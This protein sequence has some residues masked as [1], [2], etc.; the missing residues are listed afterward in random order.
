M[1]T[2]TSIVLTNERNLDITE[3]DDIT[4]AMFQ[5]YCAAKV[6]TRE[7]EYK[8][9]YLIRQGGKIGKQA[10]NEMVLRNMRLVIS[11]AKKYQGR[12]LSLVDLV[13]EGAIGLLKAVRKFDLGRGCRFSTMATWWIRQTIT[14]A[15]DDKCNTIRLPVHVRAKLRTI[16]KNWY[17]YAQDTGDYPNLTITGEAIGISESN[18]EATL[19]TMKMRPISLN[20]TINDSGDL[21]G[22]C[23]EDKNL[24]LPE[25]DVTAVSLREQVG[26]LLSS[27]PERE[28]KIISLRY[29]LEGDRC[30]TL[31]EVAKE[32]GGITRERVRQIELKA[33]QQLRSQASAMGMREYLS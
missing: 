14:R 31:E 28:R 15:I 8:L 25:E 26:E 29:G 19:A 22:D 13:Q 12:G 30:W 5:D 6:P 18:V 27:L 20:V 16:L 17:E 32:V 2:G 4:R 33:I 9:A 7:E 11:I 23:L 21:L 10:E 24:I 3:E 1:T